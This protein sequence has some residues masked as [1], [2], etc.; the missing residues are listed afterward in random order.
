[1]QVKVEISLYPLK[2]NY[3]EVI[4]EFIKNLN[5]YENIKVETNQ[6]STQI[7]GDYDFIMNLL[8]KELKVVY[9]DNTAVAVVK[10]IGFEPIQ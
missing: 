3:I 6:L 8:T 4:L 5:S 2:E 7:F 1:M 10:I 9:K